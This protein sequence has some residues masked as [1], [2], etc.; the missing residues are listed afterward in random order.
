M[1]FNLNVPPNQQAKLL[2]WAIVSESQSARYLQCNPIHVSNIDFIEFNGIYSLGNEYR[3][4]ALILT[5]N[6][7][8][9]LPDY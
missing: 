7:L 8:R 5:L 3:I 9:T 2:L 6:C 4:V 1:C